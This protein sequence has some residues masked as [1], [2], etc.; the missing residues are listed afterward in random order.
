MIAHEDAIV[1]FSNESYFH[2]CGSVKEQKC[3]I[4]LT[5]IFESCLI[6]HLRSV[7]VAVWCAIFSVIISLSL[8]KMKS[9]WYV[10]LL[11]EF[12]F[13]RMYELDLGEIWL[14]QDGATIQ[15]SRASL[16]VSGNTFQRVSSQLGAFWNG[17]PVSTSF[18]EIL[19]SFVL[20]KDLMLVRVLENSTEQFTHCMENGRVSYLI[21]SSKLSKTSNKDCLIHTMGF[22][23]IKKEEIILPHSL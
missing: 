15:T 20:S 14:Q 21:W 19:C 10:K 1:S 22:I 16:T 13:W 5:S 6:R 8:R 7:K 11:P 17:A 23:K 9:L 18:L 12:F 3:A 2:L 4:E